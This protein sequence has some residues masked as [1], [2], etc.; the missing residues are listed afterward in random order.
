MPP[1]KQRGGTLSKFTS[2]KLYFRPQ[3]RQ[4][5]VLIVPWNSC[6]FLE[7]AFWCR[8]SIFCVITPFNSPSCSNLASTLCAALGSAS[9]ISVKNIFF[10][11]SQDSLGWVSKKLISINFGSYRFHKP[12][13]PVKGAIPLSTL[14]P[15]P[16]NATA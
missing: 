7:P 1:Q 13:A 3:D 6:T 11:S 4:D 8:P 15:A 9:S 10:I 14:M 2:S 12:P 16:V 5:S